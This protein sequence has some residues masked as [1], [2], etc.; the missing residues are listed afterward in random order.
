MSSA[1]PRT[2]A[3]AMDQNPVAG[4]IAEKESTCRLWEQCDR[5]EVSPSPSLRLVEPKGK[6]GEECRA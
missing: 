3:T 6:A 1:P 2:Y 4:A 5:S